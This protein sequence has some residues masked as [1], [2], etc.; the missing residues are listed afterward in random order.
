MKLLHFSDVHLDMGFARTSMPLEVA[1]GCRLRLRKTLLHLLD[2]AVEKEVNAVTIAGDLFEGDRASRD[3]IQ[4]LTKGFEQ[5]HPIPIFIAPGNHDYYSPLSPYARATWPDNVTIFNSPSPSPVDLGDGVT[6]WGIAHSSPAERKN[7]IENFR[8][9][10]DD[11]THILLMHGSETGRYVENRAAHAPFHIQDIENAGLTFA[12]LGH[13]HTTKIL[14]LNKPLG[15]YPGSPQP[16]AFGEEGG[17][18]A[19]LLDISAKY[20]DCKPI[21]ISTQAFITVNFTLPPG[22]DA[23]G[24]AEAIVSAAGKRASEANFLKLHLSGLQGRGTSLDTDYL[25]GFLLDYFDHVIIVD[26]MRSAADL[27]EL[28]REQTVRGAFVRRLQEMLADSQDD[29]ELIHLA[30]KYGLDAFEG[31]EIA[32]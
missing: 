17:H 28:A 20:L 30:L 15:V 4:F 2:L 22:E 8:V 25:K 3:T 29:A 13:Y 32:K 16:L 14:E 12:L 18:A 24:I 7:L 9:P 23:H 19:V 31:E 6:L 26:A 5:L 21:Q 1:R 27:E 11:R 10:D